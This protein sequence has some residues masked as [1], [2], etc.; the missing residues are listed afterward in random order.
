MNLPHSEDNNHQ[1]AKKN[2]PHDAVA[3]GTHIGRPSCSHQSSCESENSAWLWQNL[4]H[5]RQGP[6][7]AWSFSSIIL[8]GASGFE[9]PTSRSRIG[10]AKRKYLPFRKLQPPGNFER[11]YIRP[12]L[13]SAF[14]ELGVNVHRLYHSLFTGTPLTER[15]T[16][17]PPGRE[18]QEVRRLALP[19]SQLQ[20]VPFGTEL[21]HGPARRLARRN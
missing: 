17:K 7:K 18:Q 10:M 1:G 9:P 4:C 5:K 19:S 15:A 8:V 20:S 11:F 12:I 2:G 3:Y 21:L 6:L 16:E 14:L 13:G